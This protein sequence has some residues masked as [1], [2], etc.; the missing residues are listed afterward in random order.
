MDFDEVGRF[1]DGN[2]GYD[3]SDREEKDNR[4]P[5]TLAQLEKSIGIEQVDSEV[6]MAEQ[7]ALGLA[8][9]ESVDL[10][11]EENMQQPLRKVESIEQFL[12]GLNWFARFQLRLLE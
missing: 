9:I 12:D 7:K 3:D 11:D 8:H 4:P 2:Y 6:T 5:L 10:S 1:D